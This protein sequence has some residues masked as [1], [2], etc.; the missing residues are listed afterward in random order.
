M[1]ILSKL[2]DMFISWA[3]TSLHGLII[4][5]L[6]SSNCK[7]ADKLADNTCSVSIMLDKSLRSLESRRS[8][9]EN[10]TRFRSS[11][12]SSVGHDIGVI[13]LA[14]GIALVVWDDVFGLLSK[15]L[16]C[17]IMQPLVWLPA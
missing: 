15:A 8:K 10:V 13:V 2:S 14:I 1:A 16:T 12:I 5:I 17:V 7:L 11:G 3:S 4:G 6:P 9:L